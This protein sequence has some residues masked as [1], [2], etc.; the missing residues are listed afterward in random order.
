MT[1][2]QT[3]GVPECQPDFLG[4]ETLRPRQKITLATITTTIT[5]A[6]TYGAY[7]TLVS[8]ASLVSPVPGSTGLLGDGDVG[9]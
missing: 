8:F 1:F 2:C 7:S 9:M 5:A 6:M 3:Q 4:C